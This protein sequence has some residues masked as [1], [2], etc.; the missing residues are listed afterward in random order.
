MEKSGSG[1]SQIVSDSG[2][3]ERRCSHSFRAHDFEVDETHT[4]IL[5]QPDLTA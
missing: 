3:A 1:H 2:G 4:L 5:G